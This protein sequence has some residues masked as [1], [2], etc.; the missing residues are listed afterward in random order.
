M[1]HKFRNLKLDK[2]DH[3]IIDSLQS[4][5]RISNSD[6]ADKVGLSQSAC[7]RRVKSLEKEDVIEGYV[8]IMNQT[9]AGLPDN[10]FVQITVE[11]QTKELL[12][13]FERIVKEC[14]QIMECYLMSGDADYMLRVVVSDASDYEKLHMEVLTT[15][16]GVS[17]IKS[18]F[19]LRTVT[20]KN[21]IPFNL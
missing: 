10:V 15:L 9:A 20:K 16:P 1:R 4:N 12:T 21:D 14:P 19:S 7:L 11:R 6:L 17:Q 18:N 2:I 3:A 8:A 13:E 5:G